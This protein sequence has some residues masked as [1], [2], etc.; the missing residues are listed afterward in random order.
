MSDD[1][2]E[3]DDARLVDKL[4]LTDG[5][6]LT[7]AAILLFHADPERF[8]AGAHIKVGYFRNDSDVRFHDDISG[9][10]LRQ[11]DQ[12]MEVL[13]FKYLR[14]GIGY[15]ETQRVESYPMPKAALREAILNA[16]VH[17]DYAVPVDIQIRVHDDRLLIFNPGSLPDGWTLDRLMG[18]H[19]S[20]PHNPD[21]ARAF[22][23]AGEIETWG[24]GISRILRACRRAGTP[25]PRIRLEPDGLLFEFP[26][27]DDYM[28][29]VGLG[30]CPGGRP[31]AP[32]KS[33]E[34]WGPR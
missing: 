13:L 33:V 14:A 22:F 3:L 25:E 27:S 7:K 11:V 1:A 15:E 29:S 16:V 28:E 8:V 20:H 21:I 23:W 12:T 6:H 19:P 24:R 9:G 5:D 26:F 17:R 32:K 4:R 31:N 2:L 18:P 34:A 10:L 30:P